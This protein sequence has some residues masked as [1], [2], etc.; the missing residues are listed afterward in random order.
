M[1]ESQ[2]ILGLLLVSR[3]YTS[4]LFGLLPEPLDQVPIAVTI[5]VVGPLLLAVAQRWDHRLGVARLDR[6]DRRTA[7]LPLV[8]DHYSRRHA[9]DQGLSLRR[10]G[11]LAGRQDQL[12]RE[13]QAAHRDMD[14]RPEPASAAAEGLLPLA[15]GA[16]PFFFSVTNSTVSLR[17]Q[18]ILESWHDFT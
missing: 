6:S 3:R 11:G 10:V 5:P 17:P 4:V 13:A 1:S 2:K 8:G 16:V 12:D 15:A 14:L 7:V 18:P 9:I